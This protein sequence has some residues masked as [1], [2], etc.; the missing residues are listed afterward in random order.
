MCG[1]E[2]RLIY[3]LFFMTNNIR[4][5]EEMKKAMMRVDPSGGFRFSRE[6][7]PEQMTIFEQYGDQL[8][9]QDL[10][11][12]LKDQI[13]TVE[14]VKEYVLTQTPACNFKSAMKLLETDNRLEAIEAP[15]GRRKF[16]YS[17]DKMK[18]RFL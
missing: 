4:G 6:G 2:N 11:K 17:N 7:S 5:L 15:P 16:T 18:L 9:A 1:T 14:Q 12:A 13:L 10:S 8:L 3:W